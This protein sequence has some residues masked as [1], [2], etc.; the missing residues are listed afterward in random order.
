MR[1]L[2]LS[3]MSIQSVQH[4]NSQVL[5]NEWLLDFP[6]HLLPTLFRFPQDPDPGFL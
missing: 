6:H 1:R 3:F 2:S 4:I 5:L